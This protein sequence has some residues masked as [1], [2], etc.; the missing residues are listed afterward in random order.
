MIEKKKYSQNDEDLIIINF[1][2]E[3]KGTLLSLGENDGKTFSNALALIELG[4]D[5]T[6]V[7]PSRLAF[8]KLKELHKD[9]ERVLLLNVAAGSEVGTM[10]LFESGYHLPDQSDVALLSTLDENETIRW[11]NQGVKFDN[12][13]VDVVPVEALMFR[14]YDFVTIDCEGKDIEILKQIDLTNVQLL[15]IEWNSIPENKLLILEYCANFNMDKIIYESGE[16]LI[17]CKK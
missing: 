16:N 7:E 12:Y 3:K 13:H 11:K 1:F 2:N 8:T 10:M 6:L 4:W 14:D 17:L 15:C 5:A 9:N